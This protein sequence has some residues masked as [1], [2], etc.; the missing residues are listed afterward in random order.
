MLFVN[1]D[2]QVVVKVLGLEHENCQEEAFDYVVARLAKSLRESR[3]MEKNVS[4]AAAVLLAS[5]VPV[6]KYVKAKYVGKAKTH[7]GVDEFDEE[8]GSDLATVRAR[9]RY[10]NDVAK[11]M[12]EI[13]MLLNDTTVG[14]G[15]K[16]VD[17]IEKGD[18]LFDDETELLDS[19]KNIK[20]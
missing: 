6:E 9:Q 5:L 18:K 10:W 17:A 14:L 16:L 8:F 4:I 7:V 11:Y 19:E 3:S 2:Q 13:Y 15:S 1:E 12:E 20:D